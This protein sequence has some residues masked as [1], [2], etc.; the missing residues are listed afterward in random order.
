VYSWVEA[1]VNKQ[2]YTFWNSFDFFN[3][4]SQINSGPAKSI[5][6]WVKGGSSDS[7]KLGKS[8][9]LATE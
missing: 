7:L 3:F 1:Q 2:M 8:G 5:P 4:S 6:V 9:K